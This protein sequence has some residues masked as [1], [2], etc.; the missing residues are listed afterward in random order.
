[1]LKEARKRVAVPSM[2]AVFTLAEGIFLIW[3]LRY[4][5]VVPSRISLTSAFG[6]TQHQNDYTSVEEMEITR[7]LAVPESRKTRLKSGRARR[8]APL[9]RRRVS[10]RV[11]I[12]IVYRMYSYG[13]L[14]RQLY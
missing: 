8:A 9:S 2:V 6:H 12:R 1:M 3:A 5:N 10:E 7:L 13:I 11:Y 4:N 14:Y